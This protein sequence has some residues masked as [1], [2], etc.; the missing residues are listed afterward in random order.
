[1]APDTPALRRVRWAAATRIIASRY[2][3]I[4]LYERISSDPEVRAALTAAE[5]LTNPRVRDQTGAIHL[6]PPEQRVRGPGSTAVMA[7]FTHLNPGG[8]RFSDGSYGVYYAGNNLATAVAET[9]WHFARIALDAGDG[10]R[11][12][13]MRVLVG[14][15]DGMF[16]DLESIPA[17]PRAALLDPDSYAAA[18]S[19]AAM[20]RDGGSRG[21]HYP[22]V[23]RPT[24]YCL[25]A[26]R[27]TAVGIPKQERHVEYDW[28]GARVRRYFDYRDDR[29]VDVEVGR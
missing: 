24:G 18:R 23:R 21:L 26:F 10:P 11:R 1:M 29:W 7:P 17:A 25:A 14:R 8:S 3:P 19:F 6:V 5:V 20:L 12:E 9:A 16:H 2:P 15:I 22:S 27:P 4:D 28:D 13:A